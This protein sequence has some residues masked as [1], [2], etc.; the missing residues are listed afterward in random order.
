MAL[1]SASLI[2][3]TRRLLCVRSVTAEEKAVVEVLSAEMTRLGFDRVWVDD[4]GSLIGVVEGSQPGP[5][6]LLDGHCD[7][8]DAYAPDWNHNPWGGEIENGRLYGRGA[9]DMKGS[10]AAMVHAVGNL[11]RS[12]LRGRAAVSATVSEE[13]AEGGAFKAVVEAL[14]PEFVVIGEATELNLNRGGRGRAEIRL[15]TI[16]RSAHSSSPQAGRC[17]VTDMIRV[18]QAVNEKPAPVDEVLGAGSIVLTDIISAP[19][20]GY[21]VIPYR[22]D[23]TYDRRLLTSDNRENLLA[24]LNS[25]P[26]LDDIQYTASLAPLEER[27]YTGKLLQGEKFFPAW[28]FPEIHPFVQS[29][30][31]GLKSAGLNPQVGAYRFCT[32]AAYSAGV[33]GIPTVGFGV[34]REED[35][36]IVDESISV[37]DLLIAARGYQGIIYSACSK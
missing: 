32:N 15:R 21:S 29:A 5:T 27:T 10:L 36:H 28:V 17:A 3:F 31:R 24:E 18:I 23:V 7:T 11:D 26:G 35:A 12:K 22:C 37:A 9:A 20:P 30:L 8:V 25:L 4:F 1:E 34:G 33:A 19:H 6:I 14:R 2:E 13:V 16:G